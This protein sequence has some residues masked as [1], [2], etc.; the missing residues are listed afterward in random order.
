MGFLKFFLARDM[1]GHPI[2]INYKGEDTYKTKI[3]AFL[4]IGVQVMVL[5]FLTMKM[6]A[7]IDMSDP[8]I[9]IQDRPIYKEEVIDFKDINLDEH[10]FNFGVYFL[11]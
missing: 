11:D 2:T 9:S 4:S 10:R 5:I 8:Y 1:L 6:I 7:L 3:G